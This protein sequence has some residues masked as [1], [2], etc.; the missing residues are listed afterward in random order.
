MIITL[1]GNSAFALKQR[2]DKLTKAF[3]SKY[4]ELALERV[5]AE[6]AEAGA[7]LESMQ[8][9][10]F[11]AESKM[12]VV[13]GLSTNKAAAEQIEQIIS[14]ADKT[15]NLIIYEPLIDKRTVYYKILK[16]KTDFEEYNELDPHELP[17]WLVNE[18]KKQGGELDFTSAKYLVDRVGTDQYLL[19]NE[20]AKLITYNPQITR[21]NID[22]L[23]EP[24]PQSKI[25]ELLDAAFGGKKARALELYEEQRAQKVEHQ[26]ILAMIAW[27]LQL[28]ALASKAGKRSSSEIAK[29][30]G[31]NEFPIRK[32]L[33]LAAKIDDGQ[34]KKLVGDALD[35]DWR[36]KTSSLDIDEALKTYIATL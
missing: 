2:L 26:A 11:L 17:K 16:A 3:V 23:T 19:S 7:I 14:S 5:D 22:L 18:S 32:A 27:Q 29:D 13:R 8:S 10:P 20:L 24:T 4:G 33:S 25:F 35:I 28:I 15:T 36:N 12:V 31:V 9:L 30:S 21:R 6:E 1:T 34:L